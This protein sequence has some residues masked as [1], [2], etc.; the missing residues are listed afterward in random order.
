[1]SE[2]TDITD[3][4]FRQK[5]LRVPWTWG[6]YYAVRYLAGTMRGKLDDIG[7]KALRRG[8]QELAR[9]VVSDHTQRGKP[10]PQRLALLARGEFYQPPPPPL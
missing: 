3:D 5:P 1:M 10:V 4:D 8:L 6:D 9:E 7:V 2:K